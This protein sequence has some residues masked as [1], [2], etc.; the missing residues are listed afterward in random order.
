MHKTIACDD[1]IV[2]I[3]FSHI[4]IPIIKNK[5]YI[6]IYMYRYQS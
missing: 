6:F 1:A 4:Y 2:F 3:N 5:K